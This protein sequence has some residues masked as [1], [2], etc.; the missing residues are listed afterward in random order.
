MGSAYEVS[1]RPITATVDG[2]GPYIVTSLKM[3]SRL[4]QACVLRAYI[5]SDEEI[6]EKSLSKTLS[7]SITSPADSTKLLALVTD[8][9]FESYS[10]EKELYY[11]SIEATDPL[12]LLQFRRNRKIYQSM[13]TK[14][15]IESVLNDAGVKSYVKI[16]VSGSGTTHEYCTQADETDLAFIQRLLS[17]EGWHYHFDHTGS[18]PS[19]VVGDTNQSFKSVD[20]STFTFQTPNPEPSREV[21]S[22]QTSTRANTSSISLA[23]HSE[24]IAEAISSGAQ[25]SSSKASVS[26]LAAYRYGQGFSDK[27]AIRD[28]AKRQMESH[29]ALK[30]ISNGTSKATPLCVGQTFTLSEHPISSFNQEYLVISLSASFSGGEG[31]QPFECNNAFECIPSKT[32]YRPT[33]IDKPRIY[34]V[35]TGTVTGPSNEEIYKDKSGQIKVQFHWDLDGKNDENTSCWLPVVQGAASNGFGMQFI[36]RIGDEVLVSYIEGDPD[37]PVVA[38]SIYNTKNVPPYSAATQSGIK[39]R[40]TPKGSSKNGN[41]LRFE[42]AKDKEQVFLH[43]EKD[44]M[45]EVLNDATRTVTGKEALTVEKTIDVTS[46]EAYT[47]KT[48]DKYSASAKADM[49]LSSDKNVKVDAGSNTEISATSKVSVDG[50]TIEIKGTTK[51]SLSVGGS[52]IEISNSGIKID[53]PQVSINGSGKAELK[54]A[55]VTVEGSGKA[56]IK[57]AM[58]SINGSAMAEVKGGAMVQIQGA[59]AKVN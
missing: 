47:V 24:S 54:G 32:T 1:V 12:S 5:A 39:T 35:Q 10:D 9:I 33:F 42:D 8:V 23:D 27:S 38:G 26:T 44:L 43:A 11:Y 50:Q 16:S 4:S 20:S 3:E 30:V 53:A 17:F 7:C 28:S 56:D 57:G 45:V 2:K 41:E 48:D 25:K 36:P 29:D 52:K 19:V 31:N 18:S 49:A 51:I 34:S 21:K 55:M 22:W 14:Q 6:T 46:K 13:S 37:R 40:S 59:I 15:I 58:V